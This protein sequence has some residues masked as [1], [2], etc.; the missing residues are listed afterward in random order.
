LRKNRADAPGIWLSAG[1]EFV[2]QAWR[3]LAGQLGEIRKAV[4]VKIRDR[5]PDARNGGPSL[6]KSGFLRW[7]PQ[8]RKSEVSLGIFGRDMTDGP[9]Q[10]IKRCAQGRG[11]APP[12][13]R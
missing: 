11:D 5:S 4:V 10:R 13:P 1:Q 3:V 9:V 8:L 12:H 6:C 7:P 2:D